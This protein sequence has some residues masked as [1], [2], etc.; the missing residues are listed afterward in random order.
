MAD[1]A[2][3][4]RILLIAGESAS[5]P[6]LER[7]LGA[8]GYRSIEPVT[9][10]LEARRRFR[11]IQPD[12][13]LVD[14]TMP[15]AEGI[16]LLEQ[17]KTEIAGDYVP[18]LVLAADLGLDV[19]RH[20]VSAGASDF[21]AKPFEQIDLVLRVSNLLRTRRLFRTLQERPRLASGEQP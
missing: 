13:V 17:L 5:V 16:A 3:T 19:K 15:P 6:L 11:E 9:D 7:F 14:F 12:L 4:A 21:L 10:P 20:A 18:M 8:A 2:D 1:Y